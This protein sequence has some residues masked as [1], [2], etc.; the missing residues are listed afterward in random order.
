M[1]WGV[2]IMAEKAWEQEQLT[3]VWLEQ[4]AVA[5]HMAQTRTQKA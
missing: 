3:A 5:Y 4:E 1:D 2:N